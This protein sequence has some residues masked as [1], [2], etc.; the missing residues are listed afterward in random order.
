[1]KKILMCTAAITLIAGCSDGGADKDGDGKISNEEMA[2]EMN[3][4]KMEAGQWETQLEIVDLKIDGLPEGAPPNMADM[5]KSTMSQTTKSCITEEQAENPGAEFFAAQ[6]QENCDVKEFDMS[7]GKIKSAMTCSA[8]DG[9]GSM[10]MTMSGDYTPSEY[11]MTMT[12]ESGDMPNNMAMNMKAT[13]TGKRIG[14]CE[15]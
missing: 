1:M 13:V 8:P 12:M 4:V 6:D 15:S 2:A 7:G 9:A 11:D 3:S 5:M 10:T 14:E